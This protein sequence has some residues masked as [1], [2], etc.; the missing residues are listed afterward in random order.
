MSENRKR[1]DQY[2]EKVLDRGNK[3]NVATVARTSLRDIYAYFD[4]NNTD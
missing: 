3:N 4:K 1:W 2:R